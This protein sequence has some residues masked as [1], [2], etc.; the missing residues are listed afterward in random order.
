MLRLVDNVEVIFETCG[1]DN[2][3]FS[4]FVEMLWQFRCTHE[5]TVKVVADLRKSMMQRLMGLE[6]SLDALAEGLQGKPQPDKSQALA[7]TSQA[8]QA[9]QDP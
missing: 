6:R 4:K 7:D 9:E 1:V 2:L 3:E 8:P 5:S